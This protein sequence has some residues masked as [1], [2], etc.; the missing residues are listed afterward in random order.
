MS[1]SHLPSAQQLSEWYALVIETEKNAGIT[2]GGVVQNYLVMTLDAMTTDL[3]IC[4]VQ[5]AIPFLSS[6]S[7]SSTNDSIVLRT[8]GDQCLLIA[9]LFPERAFKKNLTDAYFIHMGQNAYYALSH[10][11]LPML[12]DKDIFTELC[13]AFPK[14]ALFLREMRDIS[15]SQN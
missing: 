14:L 6:I 15:R 8:V 4:N 13:Q 10:S 5:I 2:L 7:L 1:T 11:N 9:G 12:F 3:S